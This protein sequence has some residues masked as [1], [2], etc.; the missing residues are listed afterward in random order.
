MTAPHIHARYRTIPASLMLDT[1]GASLSA[2]KQRDGATDADLGAVLGKSDDRAAVYR[3]GGA[4][5]GFVSFLR[6]VREWDGCF[7]NAVMALVGMKLVPLEAEAV[8]DQA[9][10]TTVLSLALALSAE[11]E[12]DGD[13]SNDD[14][15]RHR[16]VIERAGLVIDGYRERLR[17][18]LMST[19]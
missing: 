4:D 3:A 8:D 19:G 7:A 6:G 18:R 2:I 9:C 5:M 17:S 15:E 16:F 10:V 11:L 14:L 13:V 12:K 1:L